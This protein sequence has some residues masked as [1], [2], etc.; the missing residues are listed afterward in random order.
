MAVE[1]KNLDWGNLSFAYTPTDYSYVCNYKDG[2]WE[3]GGLTPD[4]TLTLSECA[5]IFHYCQEGF[6][7][8]IHAC[9]DNG[10]GL[11]LFYGD[12]AYG[13]TLRRIIPGAVWETEW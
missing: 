12:E 10:Q 5:G 4:H 11:I 9:D 13:E 8:R 2:A 3:E 6:E 7:G 1:K